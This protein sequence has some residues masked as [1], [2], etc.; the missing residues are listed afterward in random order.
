MKKSLMAA[1]AALLLALC[2]SSGCAQPAAT[3][4]LERNALSWNEVSGAE[5]YLVYDGE[6][7][8]AETQDTAVLLRTGSGE[9]KISVYIS[10]DGEK[11]KP[12]G[13]TVY[14]S[15]QYTQLKFTG[16]K[17]LSDYRREDGYYLYGAQHIVIDYRGG[18]ASRDDFSGALYIANDVMK[19]SILSDRRIT[20]R[21]DLVIQQR[22][23]EFALD[24]ENVILQGAGKMP[25]AVSFDESVQA[26]QAALV[27]S[28][29]GAYNAVLC[30]YNAPDGAAGHPEDV[31]VHAGSGGRG[32]DGGNAVKAGEL[33]L[34]AEGDTRFSG[35]N[36]GSGGRGADA[37][38]LNKHGSGGNGGN[39][40]AA[41]LCSDFSYFCVS[42]SLDARGGR[43]G[44]G[45]AEGEGGF[46]IN[47]TPGSSGSDG[48]GIAADKT[49]ILRGEL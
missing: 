20:V 14:I 17:E 15:P 47:C 5:G 38:G 23:E 6:K 41:I 48:T 42:G 30:G 1:A 4:A 44:S 3:L 33:Y 8:L 7:L 28:M 12:V 29:Y 2:V 49:K 40:G 19:L 35:G 31:L 36:G 46:D 16:S 26:P 37:S 45:G 10:E 32:G 24:L 9:R 43:G 13:E 18:S 27:L 39:G 21:A 34:F 22:A 11:G 25:A